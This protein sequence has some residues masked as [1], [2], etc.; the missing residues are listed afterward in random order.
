MTHSHS[1]PKSAP[2]VRPRIDQIDVESIQEDLEDKHSAHDTDRSFASKSSGDEQSEIL[3]LV[4]KSANNTPR[5]P[6]EK[7]L[8]EELPGPATPMILPE[9]KTES[10]PVVNDDTSLDVSE[11]EDEQDDNEEVQA[12]EQEKR[13]DRL[14]DQFIRTFIDEAIDQGKEIDRLKRQNLA[15]KKIPLTKAV[16]EWISDDDDEEDLSDELEQK[17][18]VV[19]YEDDIK[20][21]EARYRQRK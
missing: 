5:R 12:V 2:I 8:E 21:I 16:Q 1:A 20:Y 19:R 18:L 6:D 9:A 3:V 7:T 15:P 10:H 11:E 14:T 13:I 4:K 17:D